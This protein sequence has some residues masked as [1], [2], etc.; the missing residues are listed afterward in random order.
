MV[1]IDDPS[2]I[3]WRS[4]KDTGSIV[5]GESFYSPIGRANRKQ[6]PNRSHSEM[7]VHAAVSSINQR[8]FNLPMATKDAWTTFADANPGVD[9]YGDAITWSG[10]Q[11]FIRYQVPIRVIGLPEYDVPPGSTSPTYA[12]SVALVLEP[13]SGNLQ[14]STPS[15]PSPSEALWVSTR[16]N[17]PLSESTFS[18][19]YTHF[20]IFT[21]LSSSPFVIF[22]AASIS[23]LPAKQ[24]I[25]V[26][27]YDSQGRLGNIT[28]DDFVSGT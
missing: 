5:L 3:K 11:W 22:N 9:K 17:R 6:T 14:I 28:F 1:K 20:S 16:S 13:I 2:P 25:M 27:A 18:R 23:A 10:Y 7:Q 15:P 24:R 4:K 12:P 8:W 21:G 26:R 19:D